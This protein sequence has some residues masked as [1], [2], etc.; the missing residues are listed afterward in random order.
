M[1]NPS[2]CTPRLSVNDC[3]VIFF[4]IVDSPSDSF[5]VHTNVC[6]SLFIIFRFGLVGS[7]VFVFVRVFIRVFFVRFFRF[8]RLDRV[9]L[10]V[11]IFFGIFCIGLVDLESLRNLVQCGLDRLNRVLHCERRPAK[12]FGRSSLV[13]GILL[14]VLLDLFNFVKV[15]LLLVL[16][17]KLL[18][19]FLAEFLPLR[20]LGRCDFRAVA[21]SSSIDDRRLQIASNLRGFFHQNLVQF[22]TVFGHSFALDRLDFELVSLVVFSFLLYV[23]FLLLL[24]QRL[25]LAVFDNKVGKIAVRILRITVATLGHLYLDYASF[26]LYSTQ[27][28]FGDE[29]RRFTAHRIP[30]TLAFS[31][32]NRFLAFLAFEAARS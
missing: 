16:L 12:V 9:F 27:D 29:R 30:E 4:K 7:I 2:L 14:K 22:R 26:S 1:E 11:F 13:F 6:Y 15:V 20:V 28:D 18:V 25:V 23:I 31:I 3:P 24:C 19:F 17:Q 8:F 5:K 21:K 32:S 10:F